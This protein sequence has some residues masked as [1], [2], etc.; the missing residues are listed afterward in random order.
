MLPGIHITSI[1][2]RKI[3]VD[4]IERRIQATFE[5]LPDIASAMLAGEDLAGKRTLLPEVA[6][7]ASSKKACD[8]N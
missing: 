6:T 8:E 1:T 7:S 5:Q 2:N 3:E 4:E